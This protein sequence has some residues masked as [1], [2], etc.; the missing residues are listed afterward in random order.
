[1]T[2]RVRVA[3]ADD[4]EIF[5]RGIVACLADDGA[6]EVVARADEA[7]VVV[8]SA[9]AVAADR[10]PCPVVVC[11]NGAAVVAG[12]NLVLGV[13]PR[14]A[15]R[16]EQLVMTVRAAAAGL[17]VTQK[18]PGG[19]VHRDLDARAVEILR[20]LADGAA[21]ADISETLHYSERT[22]KALIADTQ[23]LLGARTR[24]QAVATGIRRGLI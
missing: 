21:T 10:F 1:V 8:A 16:P 4:H 15:L 19:S 3:V 20:Q 9:A 6:I 14:R 22:I 2:E 24:A 11:A 7:D 17:H 18:R 5:R 23:R 12:D 13:L